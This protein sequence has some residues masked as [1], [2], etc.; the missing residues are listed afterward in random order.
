M[1]GRGIEWTGEGEDEKGVDASTGQVLVEV[2]P[3]YFRP[4]EVYDL[5]GNAGKARDRLGW[6][7]KIP[8]RDLVREMVDSDI[9]NMRANGKN[10]DDG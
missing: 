5:C 1:V 6:T 9:E 4:T 3:R 10:G 7:P 8:F 2:D